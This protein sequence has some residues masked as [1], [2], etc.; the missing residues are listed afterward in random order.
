RVY[1]RALTILERALGPEHPNVA[2]SLA[3]LAVLYQLEGKYAEAE[4]LH[5]RSL[6][7]RETALGPEHPNVNVS[8]INLAI[9]SFA[10]DK[11]EVADSYF[12]RSLANYIR[13]LDDLFPFMTE[14]ERISFLGRVSKIFPI[15]YSFCFKY[16]KQN[17]ALLG[18]M[19]DILLWQRGLVARSVTA[20]RA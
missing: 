13:Q 6:T 14:K 3:N 1:R 10:A 16:A 5:K 8:L 11:P 18:K 20:M 9:L 12:D 19:Y 17:P 7:I 4:L 15:Y 2:T